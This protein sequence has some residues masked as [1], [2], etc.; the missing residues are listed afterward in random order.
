[1]I[2]AVLLAAGESNRFGG[3]KLLETWR[4]Q[5]LIARAA[6]SLLG[7]GLRPVVV[8]VPPAKAF[9]EALKGQE[10][11]LIEN[12]QPERGIGHSIALG[13]GGLPAGVAAALL[14]VADQPLMDEPLIKA[15]CAAYVPGAI[16]APRYGTHQGNPRIFDRL[17]FAEL[18]R[19]DGDRGGQTVAS[20]HR[21]Q[22]IECSFPEEAGLD[23]DRP[24]DFQRLP[25]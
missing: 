13:I 17:F 7:A 8:V 21:G 14:A 6:G 4:G 25:G 10:L 1:L 23:I 19:L 3:Q 15:L 18:L 16:V 2:A 12:H 22:V 9:S 11:V 20:A 24:S 5:P